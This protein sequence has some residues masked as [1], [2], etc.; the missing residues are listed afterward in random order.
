SRRRH[1]RSYGDWSSAV[2]SSDL[3]YGYLRQLSP[4]VLDAVAFAGGTAATDLLKAVEILREL[5]ASSARKVP[6]TAP[7]GFV[8]T[9]WRGYL[10]IG[11]A[12][13]RERVEDSGRYG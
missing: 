5:N 9:K 8:S 10:E 12:S 13:C 1:T 7:T 11:R 4:Q 3:S 2:C 6:A